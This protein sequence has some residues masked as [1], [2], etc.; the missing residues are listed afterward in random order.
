M[1]V[2]RILSRYLV[3]EFLR[4]LWLCLFSFV[5]IYLIVDFF[6]RFDDF[7]RHR[8]AVGAMIRYFVFK[9]PLV[10]SQVMPVAVLA[11]ML[12][13]LGGFSRNNEITAMRAG[14]VSALQL[15][16]PL[17]GA[18]LVISVLSFLWNET[19]VPRFSRKASTI[20]TVEIKKKRV[21]G[22]LG[23]REIWTHGQDGFYNIASFDARKKILFGLTLYSV[24]SEFRLGGILEIPKVVWDG[25]QW[26]YRRGLQRQFLPNGDV[27]TVPVEGGVLG[28]H[29]KPDDLMAAHRDAEEFD[30]AELSKLVDDLHRKGIDSTEYLVDLR[31]KASV[32]FIATVMALVAIPLGIRNLRHT[33]LAANIGAGLAIGFSFWVVLALSV[34]LGHS[35]AL[36]PL[37]AA[38]LANAVF[39]GIGAFLMLENV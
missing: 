25:S 31:L 9:I 1:R 24:D 8:A 39:S 4:V 34:S 13:S 5:V 16:T 11:S 14:G 23:D 17:L 15:V 26:V 6:D 3:T 38:W 35:G 28:L 19:V 32:P 12:L 36:P 27:D 7:L 20:N 33:S 18:C 29:E 2:P 37:V 22:I 30:Y 10:L 21:P